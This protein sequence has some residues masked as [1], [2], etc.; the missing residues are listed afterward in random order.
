[1]ITEARKSRY[2]S[3]HRGAEAADFAPAKPPLTLTFDG[4][5]GIG[6]LTPEQLLTV[7]DGLNLDGANANAGQISP[8]TIDD[9]VLRTDE[10]PFPVDDSE[11]VGAEISHHMPGNTCCW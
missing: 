11:E 6:T 5:V 2:Q 7:E 1:M 8:G 3:C 4:K 10:G 9:H